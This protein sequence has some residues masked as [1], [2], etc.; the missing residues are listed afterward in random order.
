M[1]R[2]KKSRLPPS[3][4]VDVSRVQS[5]LL[6]LR[7]GAALASDELS[8]LADI[9]ESWAHLSERAQRFDLSLADLRR[10]LGVLGRPPRDGASDSDP[11]GTSGAGS[12]A[13]GTCSLP[14]VP[15]GSSQGGD[16]PAAEPEPTAAEAPADKP[17]EPPS[18]D[19]HG[20][21]DE[22]KLGCLRHQ[23]HRHPDWSV[24]CLCPTCHRGRLYQFF[25][26]SFVSITG[27]APLV[28]CHHEVDRL[29]CNVCGEVF[30]APLPDDLVNDGVGTGWLYSYSAHSTVVLF[31]YLGV[32]PWHRQQTL[33]G[34]MGVRVPDACM[35]D[36]CET[37]SNIAAPV[38]RVLAHL[39]GNAPLLYGDD[40]TAAIFGLTSQI[41]IERSTGK[42]VERTGCHTTAVIGRDMD[43]RHIAVFRV[44]IQHSG[45]LLD[46]LLAKRLPGLPRPLVMGD[47]ASTNAVTV[48]PVYLCGCNAHALRR[49]KELES[50]HP[51]ELAPLLDA[52]RRVYK[53]DAHTRAEDM[54][55]EVRLAYHR[56]HSRPIFIEMCRDAQAL[57][58]EHKVEPNSKLGSA[59][60]YLLNHQRSLSAFF[61]LRGAPMDNNLL[62]RELRLP[63]RLRDG[64]PLFR[65]TVGAAVAA[66]LWTLLVTTILN[67][68]NAFEYLNALQRHQDDVK[69][70]PS[71][72]LPWNFQRRVDELGR[73]PRTGPAPPILTPLADVALQL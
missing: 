62:E 72:W 4:R 25:P 30:E 23:H 34:A 41:K 68:I 29:Q 73:Q 35:W 15:A 22:A 36:M 11:A 53:N 59:L 51:L 54:S 27:Q 10:M 7:A 39:A 2:P 50:K 8:L 26:R 3:Q 6:K 1:P 17:K 44:G 47:A 33:Q 67:K 56:Q 65:S 64:A 55:D 46:E 38:V 49:F 66:G 45:E 28:A 52:Y 69:S 9:V 14:D 42:Q 24:G 5:M 63:V 16:A 20:R 13:D 31:K 21:R 19:A 18:R 61:R 32:V 48:C 37:L 12:D 70:H 57:L 60:D 43:G 58:D 71:L 40:T